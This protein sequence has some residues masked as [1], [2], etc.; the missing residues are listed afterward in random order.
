MI[1]DIGFKCTFL[2]YVI[3]ILHCVCI[4]PSQ[5][6]LHHHTFNSLT[7]NT[8]PLHLLLSLGAPP[9]CCLCP[10]VFVCLICPFVAFSFTSHKSK[11][12]WFLTLSLWL[13][14][15]DILKIQPCCHRWQHFIFSCGWVVFHCMDVPHLLYPLIHWG[16]L[17]LFSCLGHH[18]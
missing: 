9:C 3:W 18:E 15:L 5:V 1:N 2:W 7:F 6:S 14:S 10:W 17:W 4:T 12:T 8:S 11:I 16:A 13:I